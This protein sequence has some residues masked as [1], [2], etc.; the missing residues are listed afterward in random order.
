MT[1]N[2]RSDGD[3]LGQDQNAQRR[4]PERP[5]STDPRITTRPVPRVLSIAG[6]DPT[7]GAGQHADLKTIAVLG[8]YGM[9]AITAVVAQNTRGVRC[10]HPLPPA[11]L[12]EQLESVS[13][14]V[15]VD[16]VKI[17]MLGSVP[18]IEAVRT[19]LEHNRP[20]VVVLDPVMV[21]TAGGRLL[22]DD[23]EEAIRDLLDSADLVTPNLPELAVLLGEAE[24]ADWPTAVSQGHRLAD[25]HRVRVLVKGGHLAGQDVPDALIA[26]ETTEPRLELHAPRVDTANTHGTGCSLSSAIA[27]LVARTGDWGTAVGVGREWLRG[28]LEHADSLDVGQGNG[29]VHH[30]HHL[31]QC[32]EACVEQWSG[33]AGTSET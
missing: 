3:H 14:D 33:V 21:A 32:L 29:P 15:T 11:V 4:R 6:T 22:D 19:W 16:A 20:P 24:A 2:S 26:P 30:G 1:G 28:A 7:G 9:S 31:A 18:V 5:A 23:A 17:G 10:I 8:G 13:Q 27:V 25:R 12:T